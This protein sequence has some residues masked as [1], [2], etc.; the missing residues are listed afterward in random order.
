MLPTICSGKVWKM[1]KR[2][3]S[4]SVRIVLPPQHLQRNK[5]PKPR[6]HRAARSITKRPE[7]VMRRLGDALDD[8]ELHPPIAEVNADR[9]QHIGLCQ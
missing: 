8:V 9:H 7:E 1:P 6:S 4:G 5:N 2:R 3:T